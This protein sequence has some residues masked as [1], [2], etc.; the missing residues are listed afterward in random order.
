MGRLSPRES[1]G[2]QATNCAPRPHLAGRTQA[3]GQFCH[4]DIGLSRRL[5][6]LDLQ[7]ERSQLQQV[8]SNNER[9]TLNEKELFCIVCG[10]RSS[11]MALDLPARLLG[12]SAADSK[13]ASL[14]RMS[15]GRSAGW[16]P[17]N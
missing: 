3:A 7:L 11:T 1:G 16:D 12:C 17:S 5:D 6:W 8:R 9:I 4:D 2:R 10:S 14:E 15:V 13:S